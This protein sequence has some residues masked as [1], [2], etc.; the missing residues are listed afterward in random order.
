MRKNLAK[1]KIRAGEP[2]FGAF[3]TFPAPPIVE[4]C[5][6]LGFDHV[7]IDAEHGPMNEESCQD[8]VRAAEV[9]G[10][11]PLIRV[12]QIVPQVILRFLDIGALGVHVPQVYTKADATAAV[13]SVKYYPQGRR[14]LAGVRAATYGLAT[15]LSEYVKQANE[16]TMIVLHIENRECV[17]NLP[18]ILTIEG[19]DVFFIGPTDLSQSLG[20]PGRTREPIVEDLITKIIAEVQAAGKTVGIYVSDAE[21][22][23]KYL[24]AGVRYFATGITGLMAKAGREFLQVV[25]GS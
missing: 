15:T 13:Q 9:T 24:A 23:R 10:I 6:H 14:G 1:Q 11:T 20:V 18:E 8:L 4:I 12:P 21:T 5:G 3:I 17:Q 22:A 7:I 25:K 16:E 19:I 2:I